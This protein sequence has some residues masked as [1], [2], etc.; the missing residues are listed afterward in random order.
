LKYGKP[1]T[2]EQAGK[3]RAALVASE[4]YTRSALFQQFASQYGVLVMVFNA[5]DTACI[6]LGIDEEICERTIQE[7]R[8]Q[9]RTGRLGRV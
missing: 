3:L 7:L 5:L 6:W 1:I 2:H 9:A 8:A 4:A